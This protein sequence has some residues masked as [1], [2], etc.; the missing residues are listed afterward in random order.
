MIL[1]FALVI[2]LLMSLMGIIILSSTQTELK[3]TSNSR[4]GRDA[5]NSADSCARI[6]TYLT[7]VKLQNKSASWRDVLTTLPDP[8]PR[9]PLEVEATSR[10]DDDLE[11]GINNFDYAARYLQTGLGSEPA[12]PHL[13]FKING[14][15]VATAVVS[16]ETKNLIPPG[17]SIDGGEPHDSSGGSSLEVGIIVSVTGRTP[18]VT[19]SGD[20]PASVVTLMYRHKI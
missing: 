10:F 13:I 5:F 15:T 9:F 17:A 12:D 20:E 11:M 3:I 6:A 14:K 2:L 8:S 16:L 1:A 4:L 7:L 19:A 18:T